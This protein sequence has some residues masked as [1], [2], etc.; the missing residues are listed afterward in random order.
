M[1]K[2]AGTG[3]DGVSVCAGF[4]K[5]TIVARVVTERVDIK[6]NICPTFMVLAFTFQDGD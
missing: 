4:K 2:S 5:E 1:R 3:L 6:L